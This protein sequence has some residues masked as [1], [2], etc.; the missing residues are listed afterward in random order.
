MYGSDS[1]YYPTRMKIGDRMLRVLVSILGSVAFLAACSGANIYTPDSSAD[2]ADSTRQAA[3]SV[4]RYSDDGIANADLAANVNLSATT[5]STQ[6][7]VTLD[8]T[9]EYP[10]YGVTLELH[11]DPATLSPA[12][13]QFAALIDEPLALANTRTPGI[14]SLGQVDPAGQATRNGR[15]A[16]V[17]FQH[18]PVRT[19][20]AAGDAHRTLVNTTYAPAQLTTGRTGFEV[21]KAT[22]EESD[23]A[24]FKIWSVFATGDGDGNGESNISDLTP[25]V[26]YGYFQ[27]T[28]S[29][30][31]FGPGAVDYDINGEVNISDITG[32][33][34]HLGE[35]TAGIEIL[36]GESDTFSA[37]DTAHATLDWT[38]STEANPGGTITNWDE[39]F[40]SW[41]GE[42]SIDDLRDA[43]SNGDGEVYISARPTNGT[44]AY[45]AFDGLMLEYDPEP[46]P[47]VT[48]VTVSF[49]GQGTWPQDGS[50]NYIVLITELSVDD[51]MLNAEQFGPTYFAPDYLS[52][53]AEA[54]TDLEPPNDTLYYTGDAVWTLI[55]G[56]GLADVQVIPDPDPPAEPRM[57]AEL[58][59]N[60]RG[61]IVV[62]AH[63]K[64]D[65]DIKDEI[66]FV[67]LS[68]DSLELGAVQG[69]QLVTDIAVNSGATV[70]FQA[71]GTFDWDSTSGNGNEV[72]QDL[73]AYCNWA[74]LT[75]P[76][77]VSYDINTA[78]GQ[79][80]TDGTSSGDIIQVTVEFPRTDDI[81]IYDNEKRTSEWVTVTI[82]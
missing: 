27:A 4:V 55:G 20:S 10:T 28:V 63:A 49:D 81:T 48:A 69:E 9:D 41:T 40:S 39:V 11:Y 65:F 60:D 50:G 68:I 12:E 19:I 62:E 58:T 17:R 46:D 59:F 75:T 74:A 26:S 45:D 47:N 37:A 57:I 76:V 54:T 18:M 22:A 16:T 2:T 61:R 53:T 64:G 78:L 79:L 77:G 36:L 71:T 82:N 13:A 8:V 56:G 43:D 72:T 51:N 73:T 1:Q 67:L 5:A 33:G 14:V 29:D 38:D 80:D 70:E 66:S 23:P 32:L 6:T 35:T 21:T 7:I 31:N 52:L 30:T 24:T 42:V 25:M 15:F 34:M 3:F 44:A